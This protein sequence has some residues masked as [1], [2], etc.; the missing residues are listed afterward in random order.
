M[1]PADLTAVDLAQAYRDGSLS[2]VDAASACL[3]RIDATKDLNAYCL[4]DADRTMAWAEQSARRF[5]AGV[6]RGPLDGVPMAV[7]DVLHVSGWPTRRGSAAVA[8]Q[9]MPFSS[10]SVERLLEAGAV[11]VGKTTTAELGWKAVTDSPLTGVTHNPCDPTLTPGGSS[12]GSAA[13]VAAGTVPIALGTDG[14]GSVR[15]PASFCGVVGAIA[16]FGRVPLWPVPPLSTLV[17][18]GPLARSVADAAVVLAAIS[19]PDRRVPA[20]LYRSPLATPAS[21]GGPWRI[22]V[23][24]QLVGLRP[25]D[26]VAERFGMVLRTLATAGHELV[27]LPD[28]YQAARPTFE[29]LWAVGHARMTETLDRPSA[30]ADPGLLAIAARG[31]AV[32]ATAYLRAEADKWALHESVSELFRDVDFLLA[33]S[34]AVEPFPVGANAPEDWP[35]ADWWSWAAFTYVF[36]LTGHPVIA[37]PAATRGPSHFGV[38]LVGGYDA[39]EALLAAA[40]AIEGVLR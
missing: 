39:D 25:R 13:A 24:R 38:Q 8:D 30:A 26:S 5:R 33:P 29:V 31:R 9:P 32:P 7:K 35:N 18:C 21:R 2:P 34:V 10:P 17:R 14:G 27:E 3:D 36:N 37:L 28:E 15:I 40:M 12:G 20:S 16:T 19:Q 22:G 1:N 4:V 23:L 11:L 6:P